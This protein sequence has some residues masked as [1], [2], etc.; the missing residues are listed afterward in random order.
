VTSRPS[1][2]TSIAA[3]ILANGTGPLS[4]A[5]E[6]VVASPISP[7]RSIMLASAVGPS[8]QGVWKTRWSFAETAANPQS[9]AASTVA[10]SRW[11]ESVSSPNC[12]SGKWTLS[13]TGK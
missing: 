13:S 8:S 7:E 11:R 9:L 2:R 10:T 4:V 6:T 12:I 3:S 1:E 5:S